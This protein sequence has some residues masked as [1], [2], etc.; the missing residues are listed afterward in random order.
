M[1]FAS[2]GPLRTNITANGYNQSRMEVQIEEN[3]PVTIECKSHSEPPAL[4]NIQLN[5]RQLNTDNSVGSVTIDR[6]QISDEGDYICVASNPKLGTS[7]QRKIKILVAS[8]VLLEIHYYF[9]GLLGE[10]N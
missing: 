1:I 3:K 4:Y 2:D 5:G 8:K 10:R 7:E 6:M 9:S